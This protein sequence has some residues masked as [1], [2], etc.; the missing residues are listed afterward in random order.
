MPSSFS[1]TRIALGS[2]VTILTGND[3]TAEKEKAAISR[4]L[5]IEIPGTFEKRMRIIA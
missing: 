4:R 2:D 1:L 3:W 5:T